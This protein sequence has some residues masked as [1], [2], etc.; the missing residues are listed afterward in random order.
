M[1]RGGPLT[2]GPS[3]RRG[4]AWFVWACIVVGLAA[5]GIWAW[6]LPL[7][8]HLPAQQVAGDR[9]WPRTLVERF[10][11][12]KQA[13]QLVLAGPPQRIVSVTLAT[14]EIL[15]DLVEPRRIAA[16]SEL[17]TTDRSLIADQVGCVKH[18]VGADVE[19]IIAL[20]PDLCFLASYNRADTRSLLADSGVPVY[21]LRCLDSLADIR[22]NVRTVGW[23]VGADDEAERLIRALD[24]KLASVTARLPARAQW[25]SALV[26]GRSGWV[27]GVGTV[28]TS[29][30]EAAGLRNAAAEHGLRGFLQV[31]EE[32]VLGLDPDLLVVPASAHDGESELA[33]L[34]EN[35]ALSPL[36]AIRERRLLVIEDR[37]LSSVSHHIADA[38][39]DL[40]RQAYPDRFSDGQ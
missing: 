29:V 13:R 26:Y 40:A 35:P 36:K 27:A 31:S 21:V 9:S 1:P 22:D 8:A 20:E 15:W 3:I 19:S 4:P 25:P 11:D 14:D 12:G 34:L 33:W 28:Q 5:M 30:L 32:R 17:A 10:P 23:A 16:F 37:L 38:V 24:D 2:E 39:V 6:H 7:P 18:F